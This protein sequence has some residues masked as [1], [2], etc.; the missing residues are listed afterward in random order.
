M[1]DRATRDEDEKTR[2]LAEIREHEEW[3][4]KPRRGYSVKDDIDELRAERKRMYLEDYERATE[5]L[6]G[7]RSFIEGSRENVRGRWLNDLQ[8]CPEDKP[9]TPETALAIREL[10]Q[11]CLEP[12][13]LESY[14]R[15]HPLF[16]CCREE[17]DDS[18]PNC[19]VEP[20][21]EPVDEFEGKE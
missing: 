11:I 9:V 1:V 13:E 2:I 5:E 20:S 4:E 17:R 10:A 15:A 7:Q 12:V 6:D 19:P 14:K 18:L 3:G 21:C 16:F 8:S